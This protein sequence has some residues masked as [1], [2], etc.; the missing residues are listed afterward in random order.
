M[1]QPRIF[2]GFE[3]LGQ[4]GLVNGLPPKLLERLQFRWKLFVNSPVPVVLTF[5]WPVAIK[6]LHQQTPNLQLIWFAHQRIKE[7][8]GPKNLG[9][10]SAIRQCRVVDTGHAPVNALHRDATYILA[11]RYNDRAPSFVFVFGSGTL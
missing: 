8:V 9:M 1:R 5:D 7:R 3:P 11:L 6:H 10:A 2:G 4:S